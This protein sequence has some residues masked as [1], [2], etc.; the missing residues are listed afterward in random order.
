[1][2]CGTKHRLPSRSFEIGLITGIDRVKKRMLPLQAWLRNLNRFFKNL[3]VPYTERVKQVIELITVLSTKYL[4]LWHMNQDEF[5]R[6]LPV[7]NRQEENLKLFLQGKSDLE[8][9][10]ALCI[11]KETVKSHLCRVCQKFGLTQNSPGYSHRD[12]LIILFCKFK[13][14]WVAHNLLNQFDRRRADE[15][16][17]IEA[18]SSNIY[19]KEGTKC[20]NQQKYQEAFNLFKKATSDCTDPIAQIFQNNAEAYLQG[21]PLKIAV[22]ISY[23]QNDFHVDATRNVLRGIADAQTEFNKNGGKVEFSKNGDK[24]VRFLEIIIANDNN[25]PSNAEE[26]AR[27]LVDKDLDIIA[28]IGHHSSESTKAALRI[29]AENQMAVI[30]P[31]STSSELTDNNFFRTL[32]STKAVASKYAEYITEHLSF[33]KIAIIYHKDNEYSQALK[34]DFERVF[35]GKITKSIPNINDPYL[36]IES[37]IQE[38]VRSKA[39]A[40]LVIS[41]IEANSVA[42]AIARANFDLKSRLK[43]LFST[44]LPEIHTLEKGGEAVEGVILISPCLADNSAYMQKARARWNQQEINWRVA[45]SYD[46]T[47]VLIESIRLSARPTR[48]EVLDNLSTLSLPDNKTSGFGLQWSESDYHSNARREYCITQICRH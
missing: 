13:R 31:T 15:Y 12:E 11:R 38:I 43:L 19:I 22:I 41:S 3:S 42:L 24:V 7:T 36:D 28:I 48:K 37:L 17:N 27:I 2:K 26:L 16:L 44:S 45:T 8:I 35:R 33:D 47:Q 34:N 30:S 4:F 25:S 10:N 14:D 20:L 6:C 29:Y 5:D 18:I 40:I 23:S 1:M 39:K 46:A 32:G 9:A 21:R